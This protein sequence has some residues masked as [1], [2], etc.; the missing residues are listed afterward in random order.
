MDEDKTVVQTGARGVFDDFTRDVARYFKL[1][2]ETGLQQGLLPRRQTGAVRQ[3]GLPVQLPLG[4]YPQLNKNLYKNFVAGLAQETFVVSQNKYSTHPD[5]NLAGALQKALEY[6]S[7]E[8]ADELCGALARTIDTTRLNYLGDRSAY[9]TN[10]LPQLDATLASELIV[11]LVRRAYASIDTP[12]DAQAQSL[13]TSASNEVFGELRR[14]LE[15]IA[16]R[17]FDTEP[18][19]H[20]ALTDEL[21]ASLTPDVLA[22]GLRVI[23]EDVT[24]SDAYQQVYELHLT[25]QAE[26]KTDLY[27]YF[28]EICLRDT[29]FPLFYTTVRTVHAYPAVTLHF[30]NRVFVNVQ[31]IEYVLAAYSRVTGAASRPADIPASI[32]INPRDRKALLPQLQQIAD[33][34]ADTLD[35]DKPLALESTTEQLTT[36]RIISLNNR[37]RLAVYDKLNDALIADYESLLASVGTRT[38][39]PLADRLGAYIT[40]KPVR[41]VQEVAEEWAAL[42]LADKLL[43]DH[44]L[45]LNDEQRQA[46]MALQKAVN[47]TIVDGA[48]GTGKTY[49]AA[50]LA[51]QSCVSGQTT[52]IL[53]SSA[54]SLATIQGHIA[55]VLS[56]VRED[57]IH[58]SP[59]LHL[60][61]ITDSLLDE[62]ETPYLQKLDDSLENYGELEAE[63]KSARAHKLKDATA[64]L[65]SLSQDTENINLQEV[66]QIVSSE[67]RFAGKD[68]IHDEPTDTMSDELLQLH[69]AVQYIRASE[70]NYLLPYIEASQQ[71]AIGI[72]VAAIRDYEKAN[73]NVRRRESKFVLR[74]RKLLP[75]QKK[76]L[77]A[78][79]SYIQSNYRQH[80][81][82]L[83]EDP[84]T[85]PFGITDNTTFEEVAEYQKLFEQ[86]S[87]IAKEARQFTRADRE[88]ARTLVEEL[89]T[90]APAPSDVIAALQD[91]TNQVESL[92]SKI[93]GFSGRT[94]VVENLTKQLKKNI[95][96]FNLEEPERRLSDLELMTDITQFLIE[97]LAKQG[98]DLAY[99][100][101]L[102]HMLAADPPHIRD[103]KKILAA[104]SSPAD[105]DFMLGFHLYEADNL[106]G[107][108]SLLEYA[109]QLN[110]VL[111]TTPSLAS[112]F[113][114]KSIGQVLAQPELFRARF[115]KLATDLDDVKQLEQ[116]KTTVKSFIKAHPDISKR[117][118]IGYAGGSLDVRDDTFANTSSE[119]IKEYL[120]HKKKVQ[121]VQAY[122]RDMTGDS[123]AAIM[124]DLRQIAA[125]ELSYTLDGRLLR[126]ASEHADEFEAIRDALRS[127]RHLSPNLFA[128]LR[129]MYP[130]ILSD[131][132]SYATYLPL[133]PDLIDLLIID[134]AATISVVEALPALLRARKV[135]V[136]GNASSLTEAKSGAIDQSINDL[137]RDRLSRS[138]SKTLAGLPADNKNLQLE[139]LRANFDVR[140]SVLGFSRSA[141][142]YETTLTKYFRS[143][144]ELI[145]YAG[146]TYYDDSL[147]CLKARIQPVN[148]IIRF[149]HIQPDTALPAGLH[150]NS[151]EA[152]QLMTE[153][154]ALR[155]ADYKGTIGILTPY[156]KQ[157]LLL[158]KELDEAVI[159]DWFAERQLKVM[160]PETAYG[161]ERDYMFYSLVSDPAFD[162][163]WVSLPQHEEH[164]CV[165]LSRAAEA[166]HFILS[167]PI[168]TFSGQ[169]RDALAHY[170]SK[171][172]GGSS[173]V[174]NVSDV[175]MAAESLFP[176]YFYATDFYKKH[177]EQTRLVT[178][179][180][181]RELMKAL[182]PKA[183]HPPY[184]VDFLAV[185]E[186]HRIIITYDEFKPQFLSLP[187]SSK[188]HAG[189]YLTAQDIYDQKVLESYGYRFL[190]LN[191]FNLG[192]KP[193]ET[194]DRLLTAA[195]KQR[196]W[197]R[198]NGFFE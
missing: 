65:N 149:T 173:R 196:S 140:Q 51:L 83:E 53:S 128:G 86:L 20:D 1:Y 189:S 184:K 58:H 91:Y 110:T 139:Q 17:Y 33:W 2:L 73:K 8:Q 68:W 138:F 142:N 3:N 129:Q 155:K 31:A 5:E 104:A 111:Q 154:A 115:D 107:N 113:G 23:L 102:L 36:D 11:P 22:T 171:L 144:S 35:I 93:F 123:Y 192:A 168:D 145:S 112:L 126:F 176:Q 174:N 76:R 163:L 127:G 114:I 60:G 185:Y 183:T 117:L 108:I 161:V 32:A 28:G 136:L 70:A 88:H 148:E 119:D 42:P 26:A 152:K 77:Q 156:R 179:F 153:L 116:H 191:K 15:A 182:S 6:V 143:P 106:L 61:E 124:S 96:E 125:T 72:F 95:P 81:R 193:V 198:D 49:L 99:W 141:A 190:R 50:N 63:L 34:L 147:R 40:E 74:F 7:P 172:T 24:I 159:S 175:L 19:S 79:L 105:F 137:Q 120:A 29:S 43:A 57:Q 178:Q 75:V 135:L 82:I 56:E 151:S 44:P 39:T 109:T 90:Y 62:V 55:R 38:G 16:L 84:I 64:V 169:I 85:R 197:P 195:T 101:Q 165:S 187:G 194:L 46:A 162:D 30:E 181:L 25:N 188:E 71:K 52:M 54:D 27:L 89:A 121:D 170:Q 180:S 13:A 87:G 41:Y 157:A 186:T 166:V 97:Q 66:E 100:K 59:V 164:L 133:Q 4:T 103:L 94:V 80:T 21:K 146:K 167:K 132:H 14:L 9:Q 47:H 118:G 78:A 160:T 12:E 130:V 177:K 98:L 158:Q 134:G 18:H 37:L 92:K 10:I 67:P 69:Y 48:P 150:T 131:V 122:F 45:P